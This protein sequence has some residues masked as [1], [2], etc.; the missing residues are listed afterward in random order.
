MEGTAGIACWVE[1]VLVVV[2]R[3]G[4]VFVCCGKSS[5][6]HRVSAFRRVRPSWLR[7][8][9]RYDSCRSIFTRGFRGCRAAQRR[10]NPELYVPYERVMCRRYVAN[11]IATYVHFLPRVHTYIHI[12]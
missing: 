12:C 11:V 9:S 3:V 8:R 4:K 2:D 1:Q 10:A 7:G 5:D 6:G